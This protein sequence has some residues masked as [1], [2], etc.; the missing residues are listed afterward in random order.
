MARNRA[1]LLIPLLVV[2]CTVAPASPSPFPQPSPATTAPA[3]SAAPDATPVA[4]A[5]AA[6]PPP[7]A[8]A[9]ARIPVAA[10]PRGVA[11]ADGSIWVA[12]AIGNRIQ[13]IDP[14]TNQVAAT[15]DATLPVTLVTIDDQLWASV[16][17]GVEPAADDQLI[18]IDP[19]TN[20]AARSVKVPVFHNICAGAGRIWAVDAAGV[21][22]S[23]EPATLKVTDHGS[24]GGPTIGI[25]A[26]DSAVWGIRSDGAAWRLRAT[27]GQISEGQ[28]GVAVP[29]RSRVAVG[30]NPSDL[31]W[32]AVPGTVLALD[33][34]TLEIRATLRVPGMTL[35]NDLWVGADAVWLSANVVDSTLDLAGGSVLRLD[36]ASATVMSTYRLGPESSGLIVVDG[37]LWAVDQ[38]DNVLA[39]YVVAP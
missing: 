13:R 5:A 28:L 38:K 34:A 31:V 14:A 30:P 26:N 7:Y 32:V 19:K 37:S 1:V 3:I 22:R 12:S 20:S 15:I 23:V 29:G 9:T 27:D 21:L 35:V 4:T 25:A 6:A 36:P 18:R 39:R 8:G 16:L 2:A 33:P 10:G 17:N 11:F 24:V